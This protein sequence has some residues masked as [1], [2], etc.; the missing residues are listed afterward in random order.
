MTG[1]AGL[2]SKGKGNNENQLHHRLRRPPAAMPGLPAGVGR[3][4]V[5]TCSEQ[6][7]ALA[8]EAEAGRVPAEAETPVRTSNSQHQV[9][10]DLDYPSVHV[11]GDLRVG[12]GTLRCKVNNAQNSPRL[13]MFKSHLSSK[14]AH[15]TLE[16]INREHRGHALAVGTRQSQSE[17]Y[18]RFTPGKQKHKPQKDQPCWQVIYV[19]WN[20]CQRSIK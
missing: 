16:A 19:Y 7:E 4:R 10:L 15:G 11:W 8:W 9:P 12:P 13:E 6:G 5:C 3:G 20:K 14:R 18:R 1:W 17:C 2:R